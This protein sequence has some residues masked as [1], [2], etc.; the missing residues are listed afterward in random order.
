MDTARKKTACITGATSGIGAAFASR[1]AS[2][3]YD[4]ILT[5][6]RKE[7]IESLSKALSGEHGVGAEVV[8]AEL[9]DEQQLDSLAEKVQSEGVEVL[10]NSA[11]FATGKPFHEE[12]FSSSEAMLGVH[13]LATMKLCA[14]Q[15][16][17]RTGDLQNHL[18]DDAKNDKL[19]AGSG[20]NAHG[21]REFS[22]IRT[23]AVRP[24]RPVVRT[25]TCCI[26]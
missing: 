17:A 20:V 11:G 1:F 26:R 10:V 22:L 13:S 16:P 14:A 8:I 24:S 2:Q 6:R 15:D 7:K 19:T 12:E 3:G 5:G 25:G 23:K 4:L 18:F 9:A 21:V